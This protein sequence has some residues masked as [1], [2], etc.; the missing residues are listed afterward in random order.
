MFYGTGCHLEV[1]H[2]L[3]GPGRA[4]VVQKKRAVGAYL[5]G[6]DETFRVCL[7]AARR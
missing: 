3:I 1:Y 6:Y 2:L 5:A 4:S 7:D